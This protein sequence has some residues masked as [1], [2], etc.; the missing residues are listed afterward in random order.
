MKRLYKLFSMVAL[1]VA[2]FTSCEN[3]PLIYDVE[4]GPVMAQFKGSSASVPTPEAGA[5]KTIEVQVTT[6]SS[7]ARSIDVSV[8]ESSTATPEM[9]TISNLEIPANSYIGTVEVSTN[10]NAL[11]ES[12]SVML[13]LNLDGIAGA[14]VQV[15]KGTYSIEMFRKCPIV[16]ENLVGKW[17]GEGSWFEYF[18]YPS[19]IETTLVDGKLYMNGLAFGW[20]QGWWSEVIVTNEPVE[21]IIDEETGAVTIAE[22]FYITSTYNGDPQPAYNIKA[23]GTILNAC[24]K[25]MEIN[26]VFVQSGSNID[27]TAWGNAFKETVQLDK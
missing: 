12:G 11:P 1:S 16:I 8:D 19:E 23:T 21:V 15:D 20:F 25:T 27:G 22:Q 14:G 9:Y 18:G 2:T 6:K 10:F 7:S 3:E 4:N 24:E 13:K 5:S 26:P 17:S